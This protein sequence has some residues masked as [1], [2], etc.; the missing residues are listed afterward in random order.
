MKISIDF[1]K[2]KSLGNVYDEAKPDNAKFFGKAE[3][4]YMKYKTQMEDSIKE[5]IELQTFQN[6]GTISIPT[7]HFSGNGFI[8]SMVF[9]VEEMDKENC[10]LSLKKIMY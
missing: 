6:G 3:E 8:K 10:K 5:T 2:H 7:L 1:S 9:N 4:L